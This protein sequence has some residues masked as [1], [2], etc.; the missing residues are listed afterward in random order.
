MPSVA[1]EVFSATDEDEEEGEDNADVSPNGEPDTELISQMQKVD[2]AAT[3]FSRNA[4]LR[5][6]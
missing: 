1:S 3:A 6:G 4:Y 5:I 2:R